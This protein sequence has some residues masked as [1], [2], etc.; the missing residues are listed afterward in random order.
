[1]KNAVPRV[2]IKEAAALLKEGKVVVYP[3]ETFFA[4]GCIVTDVRAID[5]VYQAKRRPSGM[6][7]PVIIGSREQLELVTAIQSPL[8]ARL[9]ET[10]WPGPL[11]V[12][13]TAAE[14]IPAVL[15]G[16]TGRVAVRLTPHPVAAGLCRASGGALVSTSANVSG[17]AAVT[18]ADQLDPELLELVAGI[19]ELPPAPAGGRPS[20]LVEVAGPEHV[21][22]IRPGAV[23]ETE[24][25]QAGFEVVL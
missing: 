24:L 17:R 14:A 25:L 16:E 2:D 18:A 23:T 5:L 9:G 22:I 11:S 13:V 12:L 21:R 1:M 8:V 4:V 7:L 15:T 6:P 20:T 19:V 3:T 10:F